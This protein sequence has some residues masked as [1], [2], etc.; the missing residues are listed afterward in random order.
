MEI[1]APSVT[2]ETPEEHL[3]TY[4]VLLERIGRISDKTSEP[5]TNET[6][7]R[8]IREELIG[9]ERES[10]LEH[11]TITARFICDR[12]ASHQLVRHRLASYTQE[13]QR[14]V[15]YSDKGLVVICPPSVMENEKAFESWKALVEHTEK[16]YALLI[17]KGVKP[18][19]ARSVLPNCTKTEV[20]S[21]M[22]LRS[23]RHVFSQR[24]LNP[25][26]Q[27]QIRYLMTQLLKKL[28]KRLPEIFGDMQQKI[29][30]KLVF[31]KPEHWPE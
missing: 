11:C 14:I 15:D 26:A 25:R 2:I 24:A 13:S 10:V 29:L 21:T 28:N 16:E 5:L 8:F 6:A 31:E 18:E 22:N 17:E 30:Y 27:W 1:I 7:E 23:W 20:V 12:S 9:L 4:P 3:K 19:D